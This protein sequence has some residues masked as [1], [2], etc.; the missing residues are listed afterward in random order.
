[1][2]QASVTAYDRAAADFAAEMHREPGQPLTRPR[3]LDAKVLHIF[4]TI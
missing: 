2:D 1:M 3:I 4:G